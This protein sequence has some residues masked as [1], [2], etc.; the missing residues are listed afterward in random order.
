MGSSA[1]YAKDESDTLG[2]TVSL[3]QPTTQIDPEISYFYLQTTPGEAQTVEVRIKSTKKESVQIK[4]YGANAFTGNNG[5][6]E[7]TTDVSKQDKTLKEPLT[8]LIKIE[9]VEVTVGNYEEKTV[10]IQVVPPKE[11]YKG[12]KM[13]AIVFALDQGTEESE[14]V[15]TEFSYR[16][17]MILSGSG[18]VFN[19]GQSLNLVGVRASIMRG[20]KMVLATLQNPDPKV[21]EQLTIT[22]TMLRKGSDKVVKRKIVDQYSLAPNSHVDFELDWGVEAIPSGNYLLKLDV[23]NDYQD[24]QFSRDFIITNEQAQKMNDESAFK[25]VTPRWIKGVT[26]LLFVYTVVATSILIVRQHKWEHEWE[27]LRLIKRKKKKARGER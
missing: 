1:V 25:I 24:W 5:T 8:S 16:V 3:V 15:S 11:A 7:Y 23:S 2:Y 20:K 27:K 19:D 14:G 18:D 6:I 12:I 26:V 21:L 22:A 9:P 4:I 13:G 17:G 10:R